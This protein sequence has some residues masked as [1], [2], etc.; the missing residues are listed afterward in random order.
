MKNNK[1][2]VKSKSKTYP[3]YIGNGNINIINKLIRKN[4]LKE[5]VKNNYIKIK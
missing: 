4:K 5:N 1:I 2:I 3:I